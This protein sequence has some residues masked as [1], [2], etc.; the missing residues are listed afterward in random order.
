MKVKLIIETEEGTNLEV[1]HIYDS[2]PIETKNFA[3]IE[4]AISKIRKD[5]LPQMEKE[6]LIANQES[7]RKKKLKT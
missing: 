5:L 2:S 4:G 1:S 7:F 3:E 6:L